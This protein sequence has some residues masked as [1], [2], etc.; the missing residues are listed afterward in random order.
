MFV[1]VLYSLGVS[2]FF[3]CYHSAAAATTTAT[4]TAT[5]AAAIS[6]PHA[7]VQDAIPDPTHRPYRLQTPHFGLS[8]LKTMTT[9]SPTLRTFCFCFVLFLLFVVVVAIA[10]AVVVTTTSRRSTARSGCRKVH[11]AIAP[12]LPPPTGWT[13]YRCHATTVCRWTTVCEAAISDCLP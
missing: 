11:I 10:V 4:T 1:L 12:T 13:R 8:F 9:V 3:H 5:T 7:S 2:G 6:P